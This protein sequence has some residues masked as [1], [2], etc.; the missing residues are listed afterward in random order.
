MRGEQ[1]G[2]GR[3]EKDRHSFTPHT[4]RGAVPISHVFLTSPCLFTVT[5]V[6]G[7]SSK[8]GLAPHTHS[9]SEYP[10]YHRYLHYP[11]MSTLAHT[12]FC[13]C[14]YRSYLGVCPTCPTHC[15]S[16]YSIVTLTLPNY[17]WMSNIHSMSEH[18]LYCSYLDTPGLSLDVHTVH[19]WQV[20]HLGI[21]WECP[22]N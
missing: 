15:V 20:G 2:E 17:P 4:V 10:R 9:V 8:L 21:V 12:H 5:D 11:W 19:E 6:A 14:V 22:S 7:E 3:R 18:P 1:G 13:V 16:E